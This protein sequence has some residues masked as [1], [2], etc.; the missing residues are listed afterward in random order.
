MTKCKCCGQVIP[1]KGLPAG[2]RLSPLKTRIWETV[3]RHP[4][5][6][7]AEM[8][9]LVYP[10]WNGGPE[11]HNGLRVAICQM[12]RLLRVFDLEI[13]NRDRLGYRVQ[14]ICDCG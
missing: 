12:N 6:T 7:C 4:G 3:R 13:S 9:T 5:L 10:D 2:I 11:D 8:H 14:A 1:P